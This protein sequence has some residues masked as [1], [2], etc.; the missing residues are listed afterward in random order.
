MSHTSVKVFPFPKRSQ[1][2]RTPPLLRLSIPLDAFF[3]Q[4]VYFSCPRFTL[5]SPTRTNCR[6]QANQRRVWASATTTKLW[7]PRV[8]QCCLFRAMPLSTKNAGGCIWRTSI[9]GNPV[10]ILSVVMSW[11]LL[12]HSN[13]RCGTWC[14]G[15]SRNETQKEK[16]EA[17]KLKKAAKR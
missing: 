17:K 5:F 15:C 2:S 12:A 11:M 4:T 9:R 10:I 7:A 8:F 6:N 3:S 14:I 16:K 1:E 13:E